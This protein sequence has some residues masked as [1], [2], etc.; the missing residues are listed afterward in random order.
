MQA[1]SGLS[2]FSINASV[3]NSTHYSLNVSTVG[4]SV[5]WFIQFAVVSFDRTAIVANYTVYLDIIL[6]RIVGNSSVNLGD[7]ITNETYLYRNGLSGA[8]HVQFTLNGS[9]ALPNYFYYNYSSTAN[10]LIVFRGFNYRLRSCP[11]NLSFFDPSTLLCYDACPPSHFVETNLSLCL[12]CHY[13]C[14]SCN[15]SDNSSA[16]SSCVSSDHR[17]LSNGSCLC[18]DNFYDN[19]TKLCE[20]CDQEC[21]TCIDHSNSS[22]LSCNS[23]LFR[24]ISGNNTCNC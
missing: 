17:L 3:L 1:P 20:P 11:A 6:S 4:D 2:L 8:V 12:A 7:N 18:E 24:V 14:L 13:S 21:L 16:C 22:C 9:Q 19:A 23:S 15:A 10:D 5:L